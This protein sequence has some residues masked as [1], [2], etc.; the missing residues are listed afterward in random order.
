MPSSLGEFLLG[1]F[2]ELARVCICGALAN[3]K[4]L[5]CVATRR[6]GVEDGNFALVACPEVLALI[7]RP[8]GRGSGVLVR[9]FGVH[10][11]YCELNL[12]KS[13]AKRNQVRKVDWEDNGRKR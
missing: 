5:E 8:L 7:K 9:A 10:I 1:Q 2:L 4:V 12:Q 6:T 13:P 3:C 11:C